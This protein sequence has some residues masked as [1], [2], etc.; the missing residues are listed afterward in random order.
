MKHRIVWM[1]ITRANCECGE[2]FEIASDD[3]TE[4]SDSQAQDIL[5]DRH[6]QHVRRKE[7]K[8]G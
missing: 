8:G 3:A 4:L 2:K 7:K 1:A 6:T 5:L